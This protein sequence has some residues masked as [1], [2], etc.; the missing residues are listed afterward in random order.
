[1]DL[2][3]LEDFAKS[4]QAK[5]SLPGTASPEDQLK[6]PVEEL[7]KD[8]GAAFGMNVAS[9]TEAHLTEHKV[10][11][12][13]AIYVGKLICGYIELKAPGL[14]ADAPKL[15]G[16]HNVGQW[17][18]L[19]GL[20]NLIYTDGRDWALYRGGKL[21][22][23]IVRLDDDPTTRGKKAVS[24]ANVSALDALLRDFLVW[25]PIVPHKPNLLAQYLAPLARFLR[26]EVEAAMADPAS[27]AS[28]LAIEWRQYFFPDADDS[29]FADAYA[30]TVTYALL[31]ARLSGADDL[32]PESASSHLDK[33]GVLAIALQR[34]GQ[35]EAR[36]ELRVGFDLLQRSLMALDPHEFLKTAPD[37]WLY[38]YEDF[39]AAY[40][41]K[42]RKD[43]GVY[44][45]PRAVVELQVRLVSELL[46]TRFGKRA[47]FADDG[48]VFLDPAV[49]TGTYPVGAVKHGLA[50]VRARYGAGAV[51]ARAAQMARNMHGFE[52]LIGPYAVAHLRLTQ[53]LKS[54]GA[55]LQDRLN[56]YLADTLDSPNIA[57]PGGLTLT[58]R[59]LTEEHKAA[60]KLKSEGEILVCLGNPPYDRQQIEDG[61]ATIQR[62]GGWV[63]FGDQI[64]GGAPQE[65]QGESAIFKDFTE[66]AVKAGASVHIKN[67][68]NDYVYF[69]RWALWRLFEQQQ[70][71]GIVSFIT[72]SSYL[73]GPGFIGMREAM[74][75]TFDDL[76]IIDLGG[77]NLGT[78]KTPNVFNI[79]T[80]VAI[81]IGIRG[82][83]AR[84]STPATV[85]YAKIEGASREAKL[86]RL[87]EIAE[88]AG[89]EWHDCPSDWHAPFLPAG[90]GT[91]FEW[92][93]LIDLFPW[94][95]SGVQF[96]RSWP[97][98]ETE[99]VLRRRLDRLATSRVEER[100]QLFK[101]TR[102]RKIDQNYC[103]FSGDSL[104]RV[105]EI[106]NEN[107]F[108]QPQRYCYRQFD[109]QYA[110]IDNRLGDYLR[111]PLALSAGPG[112][113]FFSSLM[114]AVLGEGAAIGVSAD[115]PDL[116]VFCGRG[117]KDVMPLYRDR[118][119]KEPNITGGLLDTL[120]AQYRETPTPDDL[121]AYV[122]ALLGGQ[123][124]TRCFWKELE[125]PGSR[126][127][128][129]KDSEVFSKAA[130]LGRHLIWLHTYAERFRGDDRGDK[131]PAG[132][133][134]CTAPV[135]DDQDRY[136]E[137]FT[138]IMTEQA[139]R[140]GEGRFGPVAFAV[141]NFEVSGLKVVQSWLGYRMKQRSG[142]K[143]SPL[144]N[145][146]PERWTPRMSE[147]FLELLW[148][149]EAT[150][151]IEP[152]LEQALDRVVSG[153]CF[154]ASELPQPVPE[155]REAPVAVRASGHLLKVMGDEDN[156]GD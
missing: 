12:D 51:P 88:Y 105:S 149:L 73:V 78:R 48:V 81:A 82:A 123:S 141:W 137:N 80:P 151:A 84:P 131:I 41:P 37:I 119:G 72:A 127:P 71:G 98:G 11:P 135:S 142:K 132:R 74:R 122:Y 2:S 115:I 145:I 108:P 5:F 91:F 39:L 17:K 8:A 36:E 38:F 65:M 54:E 47:G 125:T 153:P 99:A 101:E 139:I 156:G 94:Q 68:Y 66:P 90:T 129:T 147:E 85:H 33:N 93:A 26:S 57:P 46:E 59:V 21:Q 140:V 144:D 6:A 143:S 10:R 64:K 28:L 121:A 1:M 75:R 76:W 27:A 19:K 55:L 133:A 113:V 70:C 124:Y 31:L 136:P 87:D 60:R 128:I 120:G 56:I 96:K 111:P 18:K 16:A 104:L 102:D 109:R 14:G 112:N 117:G 77:D 100:K 86:N 13:I 42:L 35:K 118:E 106:N 79:Q 92:P 110:I 150:L 43:Y 58:Y 9:R 126:V 50:K 24:K 138:W 49:G 7:L 89:L 67:L 30:Q 130:A 83:N 22:G 3:V 95:H 62:K 34:L 152:E 114:T 146:R 52:I 69:W 116:H 103:G 45:T 154:K 40:D 155:Q 29:Q 63:R 134:R 25:S 148:V 20:P 32:D 53:A 4:L 97:I 23:V 15:K 107:A 61:D 44:Y